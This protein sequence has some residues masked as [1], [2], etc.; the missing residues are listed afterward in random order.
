ML[1]LGMRLFPKDGY[2]WLVGGDLGEEKETSP[3]QY[4][5]SVFERFQ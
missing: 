2:G 1:V 4:N 3:L 5:S